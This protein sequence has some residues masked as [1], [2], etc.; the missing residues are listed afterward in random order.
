MK[1]VFEINGDGGIFCEVFK[2]EDRTNPY[3]IYKV[4][5][6]WN[7]QGQPRRHHKLMQKYGDF[8]SVLCYLRDDALG[9]NEGGKY[10]GNTCRIG[11]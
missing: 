1:K 7:E 5:W 11:R 4:W 3:R 6:D 2:A 8:A 10:Y 9:I